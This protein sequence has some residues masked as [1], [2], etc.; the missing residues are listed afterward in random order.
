[1]TEIWRR[2][3]YG[4]ITA[5]IV[6]G[7]VVYYYVDPGSYVFMPKCPVKLLTT[8]DCPGCGF[9]RA[10]HATLHGHIVDAVNYNLFLLIAIPVT[11]IWCLNGLFI[12]HTLNQY[13]RTLLIRLNQGII[14][15]YII[16]YFV[17]FVVRN[18]YN[19]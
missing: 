18:M 17:W 13:K 9:Q 2:Y 8:L 3:K 14:Y 16:S 10:L 19:I 6:V 12:E 11:A 15:F 1:M 7:C 5:F 4:I